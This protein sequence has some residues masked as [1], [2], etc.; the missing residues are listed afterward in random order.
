[1]I[2]KFFPLDKNYLLEMAQLSLQDALLSELVT[3]ASMLYEQRN[4]PLGLN[5]TMNCKITGYKPGN[6]KPLYV[7]YHNLAGVYRYKFGDNQLE[8]LWDGTD[9]QEKY[10][11]EWSETFENWTTDFCRSDQFLLAVMDLT[12]FLP[13]NQKA[14]LAENR[15]NLIISQFF[16]LRINKNRGIVEMEVA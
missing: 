13:I 11:R 15:M 1:M 8:F 16:E 7:F 12:V 2:R 9:H 10:K 3:H 6:L 4:N 14:H 5:D